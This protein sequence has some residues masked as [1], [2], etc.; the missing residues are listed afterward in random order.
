MHN[1]GN[2]MSIILGDNF[3]RKRMFDEIID[4]PLAKIDL[5]QEN[6]RLAHLE[7]PLTEE[8]ME[9]YIF[10]E[11]DGRRLYNQLKQDGQLFEEVWLQ[12]VGDR[13]IVKEGNRRV[14]A[15]RKFLR[16]V[17]DGKITN[18]DESSFDYLPA[19]IFRSDLSAKD[20][21]IF[22]GSVHIVGKKDWNATN[23]G[24]HI[25]K[26]IHQYDET[27]ESVA[28]QLGMTVS[29]VNKAYRA[30]KLTDQFGKKYGG[31]Y[32]H[33]YS[34]FDEYVNSGSLP[35]WVEDDP[36]NMDWLMEL[37]HS[38]KISNHRHI[39]KL[40]KIVAAEPDLRE[41]C[42]KVLKSKEGNIEQA[43]ETLKIYSD[44]SSWAV[45]ERTL[46]VLDSFPI[47][48]MKIAKTDAQKQIT[49]KNLIT[50]A[51][52]LQKSILDMGGASAV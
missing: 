20:I 23:K 41:K 3:T 36:S 46:K 8:Q 13:Y 11:E 26:L 37:I 39:R 16:D 2:V 42:L 29:K 7:G 14:V 51:K 48:Q 1:G 38:K 24:K 19:K 12:K 17:Q 15:S 47:Q 28:D 49:V 27:P 44:S 33:M 35:G 34:Y 32:V 45:L 9:E 31:Q 5:D 6:P 50:A 18:V 30:Y 10:D 52:T 22:L 25:Y 43:F 4:V 40:T 21:D